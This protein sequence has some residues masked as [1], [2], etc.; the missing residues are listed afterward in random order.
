MAY[1]IRVTPEEL[2]QKAEEIENHA[3]LVQ[4]EVEN[5]ESQV[6]SLKPTFLG[7][8]A[9]TFFQDFNK[10]RGDMAQWDDI[11]RQFAILLRQAAD[12]L[13]IADRAGG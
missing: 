10:S 3:R 9:E 12:N 4:K 5:T 2:R 8:S 13:Q 1:T 11:V 7:E 6:S